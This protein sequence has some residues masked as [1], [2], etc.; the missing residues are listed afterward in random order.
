MIDHVEKGRK[1]RN[2]EVFGTMFC[3]AMQYGRCEGDWWRKGI[4]RTWER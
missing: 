2:V 3:A 1:R 4:L